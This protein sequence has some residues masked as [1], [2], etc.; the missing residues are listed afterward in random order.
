[1]DT[2]TDSPIASPGYRNLFEAVPGLYLVLLPDAPRFTIVAVTDAYA[3][4][5]M[6]RREDIVGRGLFEV[7]PDNP[8][9][10]EASG[11]RNLLASLERVCATGVQDAMAV[12]QYDV[13]RP[14]ERG[15]GFERRWW[16]PVNSPVFDAGGHLA[17]LIHRVEDVSDFVRLSHRGAEHEKLNLELLG[18]TSRMEAEVLARAQQLQEVN[19]QLRQAHAEVSRLYVRTRQ[20]DQLKTEFFANSSHELRTPLTLIIGSVQRLLAMAGLD[21]ARRSGLE[22]VERNAR[23]LL[24]HV[25]DILDLARLEAGA[26]VPRLART[27]IS[28]LARVVAGHF[29]S[30]ALERGITLNVDAGAALEADIDEALL[31]RVLL[32]LLS[33]AFKFSPSATTVSLV[34]RQDDADLVIEVSDGGPGIAPALREAVFERF[35]QLD[36]GPERR[37]G[38]TGLG[39]A[40][41]REFVELHGGS[42]EIGDAPGG[43]A[44]FTVRLPLAAQGA[45]SVA[46]EGV[47]A[48]AADAS[49]VVEALRQP[50]PAPWRLPDGTRP[51]VLVVEDHPDMR[52]FIVETLA[53]DYDTL[54]AS[55]GRD[56][57]ARALQA[58]PDLV[59]TDI[60]M[61]VMAGD[62]LVARLRL[63][64]EL[65][66]IPILV[67][68]ARADDALRVDLL[69]NGAQDYLVKPFSAAELRSRV[70]TLVSRKRALEVVRRSEESWRDLFTQA[71]DAI[72]VADADGRILDA[73]QAAGTLLLSARAA[74]VGR[75]LHELVAPDAPWPAAAPAQVAQ[76]ETT[77]LRESGALVPVECRSKALRDGRWLCMA[78]D[79]S[80]RRQS[81]E[82]ARAAT[83][84]LERRVEERTRQIHR[85]AAELAAAESR[86]RQQI[87]RDLHDDLGQTLA[88]ARMRL[89]ALE[90]H[91]GA[92][93]R[94]VAAD[95]GTL[96]DAANR[97]TRALAAQL[98]PTMLY[99]LGLVP[100]LQWLAQQIGQQFGLQV[101]CQDDE[102]DKPLSQE[103]RGIVYRAVRELLINAAKH[104]GSATACVRTRC[105]AG[106]LVVEVTDAGIGFDPQT[107]VREDSF[108]LAAVRERMS[109]IGGS[110]A[111]QRLPGRGTMATLSVPLSADAAQE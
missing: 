83:A 94:G 75:R 78:V 105:D 18:R 6:T 23:T 73:N 62:A 22:V 16:S 55:D 28:R 92:D 33:N 24:R 110:L 58:R 50:E 56:G 12:Q 84:E 103:A 68:S 40:I 109:F 106:Q 42:V 7:F 69:R 87:A 89:A 107:P 3:Q 111:L 49:S 88:A 96:I 17:F 60:M 85:L 29:D 37:Q 20:L 80:A 70:G 102:A 97:S 99:E 44:R 5:T 21:D 30:L 81:D 1:M 11:E 51:V 77:F 91:P 54:E 48:G 90:F 82:V 53:P 95:V 59:L 43:G 4:A 108:G 13:R 72:L 104:S 67:L 9:D 32:N 71:T 2:S 14:E 38:G 46:P 27:N 47:F 26:M 76:F 36:N 98:A 31:Q 8:A 93:V 61:P 63:H 86:E 34:V 74:L 19:E 57:L 100:A 101:T 39:L 45:T 64:A 52:R 15:G 65:A 25:N 41:V 10:V 79:I 66:D 35:R